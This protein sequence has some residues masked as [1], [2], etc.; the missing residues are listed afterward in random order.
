[1]THIRTLGPRLSTIQP[2]FHHPRSLFVTYEINVF[3]T[4]EPILYLLV[5]KFFS[6]YVSYLITMKHAFLEN[7]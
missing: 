3:L 4:F 2:S 7:P 5:N 6:D 1:M